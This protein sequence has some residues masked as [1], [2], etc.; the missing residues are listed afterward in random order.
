[1]P[2]NY[3][4]SEL[5]VDNIQYFNNTSQRASLIYGT[6]IVKEVKVE[7]ILQGLPFSSKIGKPTK[8]E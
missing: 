3:S 8:F 6:V 2:P 4:T 5:L 7:N 1:M